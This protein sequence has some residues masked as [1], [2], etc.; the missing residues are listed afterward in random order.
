M[1]VERLLVV[2]LDRQE[3]AL[4]AAVEFRYVGLKRNE[5]WARFPLNISMKKLTQQESPRHSGVSEAITSP[6]GPA[7]AFPDQLPQTLDIGR[8]HGQ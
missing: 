6:A 4:P 5:C 8:G 3:I 1:E 7:G 2:I